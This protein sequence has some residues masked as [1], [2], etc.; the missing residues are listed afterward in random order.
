MYLYSGA[1]EHA[2]RLGEVLLGEVLLFYSGSY[3]TEG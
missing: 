1:G 2:L 3:A